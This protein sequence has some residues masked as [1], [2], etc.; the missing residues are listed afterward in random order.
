MVA[1]LAA[2]AVLL[3]ALTAQPAAAEFS[4]EHGGS[5][6]VSCHGASL[7]S[8]PGWTVPTSDDACTVCHSGGFTSRQT[9]GSATRT[10]WTCHDAN[11]DMSAVQS[12][13]GCGTAAAGAACHN[14]QAHF[15][16]TV[17]A[18]T[19]CHG[20][21][22]GISDPGTSEH[23]NTT[24]NNDPTC[25][26]CHGTL[27]AEYV[28]GE[29][30]TTCH[31]GYETTHPVPA[32]VAAPTVVLAAKPLIVKYGLTTIVSGSVKSGTAGLAGKTVAL[33]A[34]PVGS[35]DFAAVTTA[36][37]AADG[38]Y[39]FVAQSP[40][41]LTTYRVVT[42]GG[43]VNTTVV[44]PSLKILD[45][46]VRPDLTIAVSKTKFLLGGKVTIKGKVT[47]ARPGGIVKLTIQRKISGVWKNATTVK[48]RTLS[49]TSTYSYTYKPLKRGSYR[50]K[51]SIAA[52]TELAAY[53]TAYKTWTV[54]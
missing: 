1:V 15:G 12:A 36:T 7:P 28:A 52:T 11:E 39:A 9:A 5:T 45:V 44:K 32:T 4:W 27:H 37:T 43:V 17:A 31:G 2:G 22:T 48:S 33:Q 41:M 13:A 34:K 42:Y 24:V 40:T 23:H 54:K 26:T 8:E 51:A 18:C 25:G 53:T 29:A 10:C 3:F 20:T 21:V 19:T 14:T 47:P 38:A 30:C 6:C 50:V 49:A 35:A 46:K 16:S